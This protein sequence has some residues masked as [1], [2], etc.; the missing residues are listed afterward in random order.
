MILENRTIIVTG[1]AQGIGA[2]LV[3]CFDAQAPKAITLLDLHA[4]KLEE[5]AADLS[6]RNVSTG[7]CDVGD[8]DALLP[9][10]EAMEMEHGGVDLFCANAGVFIPGG[11]DVSLDGWKNSLNVNLMSH[12]YAARTCLPG[13]LARGHGYFLHTVSAAGLLSQIG[14]AP[15]TVSKHGALAFAEWLSITYGDRG[16]GVTALC[17]QGVETPMLNDIGNVASVSGDGLASSRE[18]A[19]CALQAIVEERFLALP[20]PQV[21]DYF[22]FKAEDPD[23]WL[24]GMRR[25]QNKLVP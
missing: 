15:Y 8:P 12:I 3:R 10:V 1:A 11:E 18:V 5:L 16:I 4:G 7:V 21:A 17:P 20:H 13:M 6:C 22:R 24:K 25:L 2:A 23:R 19:E 9:F 14:S